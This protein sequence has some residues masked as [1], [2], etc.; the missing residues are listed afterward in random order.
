MVLVRKRFIE[1]EDNILPYP[2]GRAWAEVLKA[3]DEGG[4]KAK[5]VFWGIILGFIYKFFSLGLHY[6]E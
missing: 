6:F 4:E 3:G 1:D 5:M 2:E